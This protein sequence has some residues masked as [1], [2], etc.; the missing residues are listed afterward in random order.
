MTLA[1]TVRS[2]YFLLISSAGSYRTLVHIFILSSLHRVVWSVT[3]NHNGIQGHH[4]TR[5]RFCCVSVPAS[6]A[7]NMRLCCFSKETHKQSHTTEPENRLC[8]LPAGT[9]RCTQKCPEGQRTIQWQQL[10]CPVCR[11]TPSSCR[12]L[13]TK[14]RLN[15]L[16]ARPCT[17]STHQAAPQKA[18]LPQKA[19]V[20][21]STQK[22]AINMTKTNLGLIAKELSGLI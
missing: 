3:S 18:H 22:C 11:R 15:V 4:N 14:S 2:G 5:V 8:V 10:H 16:R 13:F 6:M 1:S 19:R 7:A 17:H 20:D 12:T 9:C 21:V